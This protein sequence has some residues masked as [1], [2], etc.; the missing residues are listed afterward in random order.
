MTWLY[1]HMQ[2]TVRYTDPAAYTTSDGTAVPNLLGVVRGVP[3]FFERCLFP[4]FV[5]DGGPVSLKQSRLSSRRK[6]RKRA[7]AKAKA[8]AERGDHCAAARNRAQAQGLTK[9][10]R[11]TTDELLELLD[12][13]TLVAPSEAE[14]QAAHMARAGATEYV[15][16]DD[17][18][19]LLY[20]APLTLREFASAGRLE[21][22][23]FRATLDELGLTRAQLVDVAILCG[24]DYNDGVPGFGPRRALDRLEAHGR[25]W[26]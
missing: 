13:P 14:A 25:V 26:A 8:A 3:A 1:R 5:F 6:R 4:V 19:A 23:D 11:Q 17:Y 18:D 12:I 16:T 15:V 20:G 10:I 22:M 2:R 24:T 7:D 9:P 21:C